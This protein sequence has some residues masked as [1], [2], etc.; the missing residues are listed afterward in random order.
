MKNKIILNVSFIFLLASSIIISL[1]FNRKSTLDSSIIGTWISEEDTN[2]KMI[3]TSDK[4]KWIYQNNQTDEYNYILTNTSPQCGSN[5]LVTGETKYLQIT[6]TLNIEDKL[7]YEIYGLSPTTL[8]LREINSGG[9]KVFE[10][11]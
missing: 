7:C 5:V 1:A 3:F 8:T 6:N 10:R 4:C 11:Q 9:F 2:W